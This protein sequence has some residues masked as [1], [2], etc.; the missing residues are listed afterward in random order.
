MSSVVIWQPASKRHKME[1]T[2]RPPTNPNQGSLNTNGVRISLY[3]VVEKWKVDEPQNVARYRLRRTPNELRLECGPVTTTPVHACFSEETKWLYASPLLITRTCNLNESI[4][5]CNSILQCSLVSMYID[6]AQSTQNFRWR[7]TPFDYPT[8]HPIRTESKQGKN[9]LKYLQMSNSEETIIS[10][11]PSWVN[12]ISDPGGL[13]LCTPGEG[14]PQ[15]RY[16]RHFGVG[17]HELQSPKSSVILGVTNQ[18]TF[19]T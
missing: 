14:K 18:E 13:S 19:C 2:S 1:N 16:T 7:L 9:D 6:K 4:G 15:L 8:V 10:F 5:G 12:V 17:V 11:D 3:R